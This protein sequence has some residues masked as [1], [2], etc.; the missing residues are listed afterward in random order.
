MAVDHE[1][2]LPPELPFP[3]EFFQPQFVT[4]IL[5]EVTFG[6]VRIDNTFTSQP[7]SGVNGDYEPP[8]GG[9]DG[10]DE[11]PTDRPDTGMLY[12]RG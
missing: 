2:D 12:P 10:G 1:Y 6:P 8:G 9:D 11:C 3:P 4:L 7:L 5:P